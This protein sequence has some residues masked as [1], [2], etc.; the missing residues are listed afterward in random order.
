MSDPILGALT[1][2]LQFLLLNSVFDGKYENNN[3][4]LVFRVS[5]PILGALT[6][7]LNFLLLHSVF[8]YEHKN[9]I[10]LTG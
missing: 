1:L 6:L 3:F 5:D 4:K 9:N 10:R 7:F 2:F 8:D